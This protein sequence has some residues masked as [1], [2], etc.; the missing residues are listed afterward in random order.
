M[1]LMRFRI[2]T[3]IVA[4]MVVGVYGQKQSKTFNEVFNVNAQTVLDINTSNTDIEFETWDK[5]Q[6]AVEA[7][8]EVD[9]A[10][11]EEA[12]DYFS[13]GGIEIVGNS[14]KV[15]INTGPENKWSFAY[16][17]DGLH[18]LNIDIPNFHFEMPE[19][20]E[21]PEIHLEELH[22]DL[23]D[24]PMPP[25]PAVE[26]D[27]EAYKKDGDKY[28]KKWQK[29]FDK[30]FDKEYEQKM[31]AWSAKMEAKQEEMAKRHE[32]MAERH[33]A[34]MQ[35]RMEVQEKRMEE[36]AEAMEKRAESMARR[37][38]EMEE[39]REHIFELRENHENEPNIFYYSSDG[40][41]KKF[42]I[43]K[44]IKIKM[45]K[46]T[47]I[48]MNVRHGEVKLAGNTKNI[49]ARLTYSTLLAATIDGDE[50]SI[51]TS[52]SPVSVQKWNYG[53]L[54]AD[55]SEHVDLKEVLN[56]RLSTTSSDVTIHKL[57]EQAVIHNR[58]G[59]LKINWVSND[60]KEIDI[61]L[62]NA[63]LTCNLPETAFNIAIDGSMS[64]L[65]SPP[66]LKLVKTTHNNRT[67]HTGYN[68]N[69]NSDKSIEVNSKYSE[70]VL[71]N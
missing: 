36:R 49:N 66:N 35:K 32:V 42:K 46:G 31:E 7:T 54:Q 41:N 9:G 5:N 70:V 10:T 63:E 6:I 14:K 57:L 48:K 23:S 28:L 40:E 4:L 15:E 8:I 21:M 27:Y 25:V 69:K 65:T 60:F 2:I 53:L 52:Y 11:P 16:S 44:T 39:R 47:K 26:F 24:M 45:P 18:N 34:M 38:E 62:Q 71:K 56:L 29:K 1:K 30:G 50:T 13:D 64:K 37:A 20:P 59:P 67:V 68:V 61:S 17:M 3:M 22:I 33:E 58:M 51:T 19:I 12:E 55:Y 43:K